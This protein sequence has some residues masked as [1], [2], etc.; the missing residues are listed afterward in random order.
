MPHIGWVEINF[1]LP[2]YEK[3]L[4]VPFIVTKQHLD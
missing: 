2:S 1:R 4:K 3:D